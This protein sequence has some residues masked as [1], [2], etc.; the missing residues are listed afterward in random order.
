MRYEVKISCDKET[1]KGT[2]FTVLVPGR[3]VKD[4]LEKLGEIM[5]GELSID[6]GRHISA[7]Q[8]K[9]IYATVK[10]IAEYTGDAPESAKENLK[11]QYMIQTGEPHFSLASC[12][13]T[14]AREFLTFILDFCLMWDVPLSERAVERTDDIDAYLWCCLK[15]HKCA[16]CGRYGEVHHVDHIGMG[17][18]R[19]KVDDSQKRKICLCREHHTEVHNIGQETFNNK[20]KVKGVI[21]DE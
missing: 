2:Y 3:Q 4:K 1:A 17:F 21:Y 12:S 8:R 6:D 16:V 5:P 11:Y 13:V 10:D 18:N 7:R 15:H 9:A 20:Y 14:T 19:H